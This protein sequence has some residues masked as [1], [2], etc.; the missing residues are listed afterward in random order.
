MT[1]ACIAVMSALVSLPAVADTYCGRILGADGEKL[2][3]ATV[4]LQQEPEKGTATNA[5]GEFILQ[6]E[7]DT[8]ATVIASYV[9]YEKAVF[10]LSRLAATDDTCITITLAEQPIALQ[11]TVVSEKLTKRSRRKLLAQILHSV[12]IKLL[13]DL[14]KEPTAYNV[15]SDVRLDAQEHPWG[16]E[17]MIATVTEHPGAG[18]NGGDSIQLVAKYCKRF[19]T[20]EVRQR[21]DSIHK[22]E[23]DKKRQHLARTIDNGTGVHRSLWRMRLEPDHLLDTSNELKRWK[24]SQENSGQCVLTYTRKYDFMGMFKA[25][26]S[27]NL[28]IDPSDY[29]LQA[30]TVDMQMSFFLL[31]S[32]KMKGTLLDWI[33]L[34]NLSEQDFEKFRLRRGEM[35]ASLSTIYS[36]NNGIL[37]PQEKNLV[38]SGYVQ[39]TKGNRIPISLKATQM[40]TDIVTEGV[41]LQEK[42][43]KS[44]P[45]RR[46]YVGIY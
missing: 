17:Q 6:T 20:P 14:P 16:M 15:V 25:T 27:E 9:G 42:Y 18:Y 13:H 44:A 32:Y 34:F 23:K 37:V 39:D 38:S 19:C 10:H 21:L 40:V 4:Y 26:I 36:F 46:E 41:K 11:E 7:L 2:M 12:Y 31:F 28:I 8:S 3:Y 24:T 33:N 5:E 1:S 45:V 29:T 30:Y 22:K 35:H 43:K